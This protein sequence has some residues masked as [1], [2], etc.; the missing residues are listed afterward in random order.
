MSSRLKDRKNKLREESDKFEESLGEEF[1]EFAEKAFNI[2]QKAIII[3][4]GAL[5]TYLIVRALLGNDDKKNEKES[6]VREKIIVQSSPKSIFFKSLTDK[7]SLVLLELARE[8]ILNIIKKL[9][10]EDAE[11]DI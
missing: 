1:D 11:K 2:G 7:A 3:G 4:G 10:E 6:E 8:F 9:P 5:V